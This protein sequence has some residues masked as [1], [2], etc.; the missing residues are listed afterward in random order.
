MRVCLLFVCLWTGITSLHGQ[1][2]TAADQP[3][4]RHAQAE[5]EKVRGLVES[6]V[7]PRARLEQAQNALSDAQDDALIRASLYQKDITVEQ[8]DAL[9]AL[10]SNRM[11]R[12]QKSLNERNKLLAEGIIAKSEVG[13][14]QTGLDDA[15]RDLDWAKNRAQL[16]C[17]LA[18]IAK[19][20]QEIMRQMALAANTPSGSNGIVEH[21]VGTNQFDLKQLPGIERAFEG[22][23]AHTMPVSALGE[24]SV[25][26]A[27]GFDHRNRVDIALQPDQ[28][29]G[30]WLRKYLSAHNIPYFAFRGAVAHKATGAHIHI[31]PPSLHYIAQTSRPQERTH[32]GGD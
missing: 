14:A 19:S 11:E 27:L 21:F 20:E 8:A 23:F 30:Q 26:R 25:H 32:T 9:V 31:G 22:R 18:E 15:K 24:T 29:E 5:L 10:T 17:E 6:G 1:G 12:R 13:D 3:A 4:V 16:A 2:P 7:L 28:P